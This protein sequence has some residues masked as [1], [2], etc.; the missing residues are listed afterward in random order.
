MS[1]NEKISILLGRELAPTERWEAAQIHRRNGEVIN[2]AGDGGGVF[3]W[4]FLRISLVH[5]PTVNI[6]SDFTIVY[7]RFRRIS[8]VE[9]C[10]FSKGPPPFSVPFNLFSV[11]SS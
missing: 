7:F 4:V 10:N 2:L 11:I 8:P 1:K 6:F 9:A 3:A 5:E